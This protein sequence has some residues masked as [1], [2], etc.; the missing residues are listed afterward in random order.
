MGQPFSKRGLILHPTNDGV[1]QIFQVWCSPLSH[2]LSVCFEK[3]Y[4]IFK[5]VTSSS[6]SFF[7]VNCQNCLDWQ[8]VQTPASSILTT[9]PLLP[10]KF[11]KQFLSPF[12]KKIKRKY[13]KSWNSELNFVA[14]FSLKG[15]F[16]I[17]FDLQLRSFFRK[18]I[19]YRNCKRSFFRI[20]NH[21]WR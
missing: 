7:D 8:S 11:F 6:S 4:L 16:S 17:F 14:L 5:Q 18:I 2:A 1:K 10:S 3:L 19:I 9:S 13:S 21:V 12:K 20:W 15:G